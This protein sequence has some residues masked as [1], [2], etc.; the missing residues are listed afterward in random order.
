MKSHP[1]T[2]KSTTAGVKE[3]I[4]SGKSKNLAGFLGL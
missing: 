2:R 1:S 3:E 4:A